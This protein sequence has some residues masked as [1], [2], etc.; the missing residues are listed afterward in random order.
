MMALASTIKLSMQT[1]PNTGN[2]TPRQ[3][4]PA[5]GRKLRGIP[6]AYPADTV[7]IRSGR[8]VVTV[9]P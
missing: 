5:G 9:L 4:T 1:R 6:S 3:H 2:R 8:V 7:A